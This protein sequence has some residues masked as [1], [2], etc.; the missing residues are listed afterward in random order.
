MQV[1]IL[2]LQG[3]FQ[4]HREKLEAL[5]V[6]V[7]EVRLPKDLQACHGLILPGGE[8]TTMLKLVQA[9]ELWEPLCEFAKQKRPILGTCAGAILMSKKVNVK[10]QQS[11][12]WLP[13]SIDRNAYGSQVRSFKAHI[14]CPLWELEQVEAFFI[15]APRFVDIEAGV[16]EISRSEDG[17]NGVEFEN[18]SAVTY[19]PE[20]GSETRFHEAWLERF[21]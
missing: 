6:A 19:H 21:F 3:G 10:D 5:N 9:Y 20:L 18:F 8:S 14:D 11:F 4:A 15:R 12:G 17:I 2:A 16:K 7:T 13:V 1:G